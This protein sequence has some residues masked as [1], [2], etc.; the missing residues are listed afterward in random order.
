MGTAVQYAS[1]QQKALHVYVNYFVYW[2]FHS[3]NLTLISLFH[4]KFRVI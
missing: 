1:L 2:S 3:G 4:T